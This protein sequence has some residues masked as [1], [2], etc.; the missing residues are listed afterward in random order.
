MYKLQLKAYVTS[1]RNKGNTYKKKQTELGELRNELGIQN[2]TLEQLVV[3]EK[4]VLELLVEAEEK[5]GISGYFSMQETTRK[6]SSA[7]Q[8]A[9]TSVSISQYK[10]Q[11]GQ[12]MSVEGISGS[13]KKLNGDIADK[14]TQLAPVIKDLRPLRQQSQDLQSEYDQKKATYDATAAG[15]ESALGKLEVEVKKLDTEVNKQETAEFRA[16]CDL[17]ILSSY[18]S[19]LSEESKCVVSTSDDHPDDHDK[20]S[21]IK[22]KLQKELSS[23]LELSEELKSKQKHLKENEALTKRQVKLW[24]DLQIL[25]AVKKKGH[26]RLVEAKTTRNE[27]QKQDY[28]VL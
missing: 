14:K 28:L 18:E 25:F 2:R 6:A 10:G 9:P 7:A 27:L 21:S 24:K 5:R 20:S 4:H 1:I 22:A 19:M 3:K 15:L 11:V 26:Q 23:E 8:S 16:K 17:Q 12:E 13:I